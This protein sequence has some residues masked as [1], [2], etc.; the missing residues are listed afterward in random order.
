[1]TEYLQKS[2]AYTN[3]VWWKYI[4]SLVEKFKFYSIQ[5]GYN[6][7]A[8]NLTQFIDFIHLKNIHTK[9]LVKN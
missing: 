3:C 2:L 8:Y 5:E 9:N 6:F 4:T 1:M 7:D